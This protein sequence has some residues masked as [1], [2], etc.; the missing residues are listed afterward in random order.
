[1]PGRRGAVH[2]DRVARFTVAALSWD[3]ALLARGRRAADCAAVSARSARRR[4]G[5]RSLTPMSQGRYWY[6]MYNCHIAI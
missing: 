3:G 5:C 1:M 6:H 2:G 4:W